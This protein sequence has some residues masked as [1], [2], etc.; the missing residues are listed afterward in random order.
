MTTGAVILWSSHAPADRRVGICFSPEYPVNM[1]PMILA[2]LLAVSPL[3]L[4]TSSPPHDFPIKD[5]QRVIFLGDSNMYAGMMV[6]YFEAF[7]Y[8][9]FPDRTI[10]V[11]D[12][13][14][15]SETVSGLS[16]PD[17]PYPRPW[18]FER[19]DRAL[20]KTKPNWVIACYG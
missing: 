7:I 19:L 18:L 12:L 10:D 9:N 16:E 20:A 14:L 3:H 17:H 4:F 8:V 5:G 13:G 6:Q 15:P 2:A 11:I 1:N